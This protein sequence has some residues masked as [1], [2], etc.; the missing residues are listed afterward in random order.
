MMHKGIILLVL[1]GLISAIQPVEG[2]RKER[3]SRANAAYEAGEYYEAIDLFKRAYSKISDKD[4]RAGIIFKIA[5]C[6]RITGQPRQAALWYRKALQQDY[7]DPGLYL[8]YG[9]SL[10]RYE[11]F[12]EAEE[13]FTIYNELVPDDPRG[14][15]GV[16]SARVAQEWMSNTTGYIVEDMRYFNSFDRDW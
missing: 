11:R 9:Q 4:R 2:Q 5:E 1:I 12:E 13:Q 10:M 7:Q 6:Y 14:D 3:D 8:R 15:W 16:E